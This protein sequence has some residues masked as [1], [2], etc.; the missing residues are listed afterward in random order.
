M[1]E[2]RMQIRF[3]SSE[4]LRSE[5]Q[6]NIMNRGIFVPTEAQFA[7]RQRVIVDIVLD[8]VEAGGP[9]L[10]LDGEVV[11]RIGPEMA[12]S[13]AVPGV[14]IQFEASAQDLADAFAPLLEQKSMAALSADAHGKG[15]REARR[16]SVRVPVRIMPASSPPFEATS[17]DLSAGGILL[18]MRDV[19]LPVGEVVRVCLWHPSG[20]PSIEID[21]KVIR[22]IKNKAGRIAAVAVAFDRYQAADPHV[23]EVIDALRH[24]GHRSRLGAISGSI[25]DH[26]FA[27]LLQMFASSAPCGTLIVDR[28][29]EQGW[30]AF[31]DGS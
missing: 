6:K 15:R 27:N 31:A 18:S 11:H 22:Q 13:G 9:A 25:A 8:Y 7:V 21:G 4:L 10:S 20:D 17:R 14:A 5:F 12:A 23:C 24:A 28:D 19:V 16:D 26:G 2:E 1:P 3:D 29:G 30:V